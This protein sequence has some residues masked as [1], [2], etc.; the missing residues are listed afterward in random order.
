MPEPCEDYNSI[1]DFQE[2]KGTAWFFSPRHCAFCS[3]PNQRL[4]YEEELLIH[5]AAD[6]SRFRRG[7]YRIYYLAF[8][9]VL[10]CANP[11]M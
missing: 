5:R 8:R 4:L 1:M 9:T 11:L 10:Y 3:D 2:G 6:L 7:L